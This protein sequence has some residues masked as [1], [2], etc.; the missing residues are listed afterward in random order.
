[1]VLAEYTQPFNE[2]DISYFKPI[3]QRTQAALGFAPTHWAADAAYDAWYVYQAA[4]EQ[5]G[6]VAVPFNARGQARP[7]LDARGWPVCARGLSMHAGYVSLEAG[8]F[9][10]QRLLCPLLFPRPTGATCDH[11]QFL[12][13]TGCIK[14]VNIELGGLMRLGLDRQSPAYRAIYKQRTSTERINSQAT[15]LGI[16]RPHVRNFHSVRNLNTL[17]YILIV[18]VYRVPVGFLHG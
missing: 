7:A 14:Q 8:G 9:H 17:T 6:I 1:M 15:A 16:E 4:A 5:G 13:G 11:E 3:R 10:S 12:K 2:A 18:L